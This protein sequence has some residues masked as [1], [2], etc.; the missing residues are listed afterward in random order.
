MENAFDSYYDLQPHR[1]FRNLE[2]N[3]V[4]PG[5]GFGDEIPDEMLDESAA[6]DINEF[7]PFFEDYPPIG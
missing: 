6:G 4:F 2:D 5:Y 3:E 7:A 1:S